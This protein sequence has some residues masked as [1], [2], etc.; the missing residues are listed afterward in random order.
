MDANLKEPTGQPKFFT[1]K[2]ISVAGFKSI[3]EECSVTLKPLTVL[4]G[5]NSSGKSSIFQLLL[6]LKQ[7]LEASYDPGVL[8]LMGSNVRFASGEQILSK[9]AS[10]GLA[11]IFKISMGMSDGEIWDCN[12][13][14]VP[15]AGF[16]LVKMTSTMEKNRR[17]LSLGKII[18]CQLRFF[19]LILICKFCAEENLNVR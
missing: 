13:E 11:K 19:Q 3:G 10:P 2:K 15:E 5:A 14:W 16:A 8:K 12:Y 4:A 7:T 6:L 18:H 9:Q 17:I 1:L